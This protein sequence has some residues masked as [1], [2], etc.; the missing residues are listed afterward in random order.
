MASTTTTLSPCILNS[1]SLRTG[2]IDQASKAIFSALRRHI[3]QQSLLPESQTYG[4]FRPLI[5]V[6]EYDSISKKSSGR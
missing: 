1:H 3:S 6:I 5:K 4:H 2:K